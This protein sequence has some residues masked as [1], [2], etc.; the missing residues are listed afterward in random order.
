MTISD[1]A[2][3]EPLLRFQMIAGFDGL[4]RQ[5]NGVS[6]LEEDSFRMPGGNTNP[7]DFLL[8]DFAFA[9]DDHDRPFEAVR[10]L[11]E[12]DAA[13]LAV[14][15]IY[16]PDLD[17]RVLDYADDNQ[18]PVFLFDSLS[19]TDV[20]FSIYNRLNGQK[21]ADFYESRLRQMFPLPVSD[22]VILQNVLEINPTF[23]SNYYCAYL[24]PKVPSAA[25]T[26]QNGLL[27]VPNRPYS[28]L[29]RY[30][31][32]WLLLVSFPEKLPAQE[33]EGHFRNLLSLYQLE[34]NKFFCGLSLIYHDL[35]Q[36]DLCLAEAVCASRLAEKEQT[37]LIWYS[38]MGV[39]QFLLPQLRSK[40][41]LKQ[42]QAMRS[43]LEEYDK[44]Y[45]SNLMET[46][47]TYVNCEGKLAQT[48]QTLYLH[49]N[50]V[51]Y[52][53]DKLRELLGPE[54]FFVQAYLFVKADDFLRSQRILP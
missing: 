5:V 29:V 28:S 33:Q 50:T 51:R 12:R 39:Y 22:A 35:T 17:Q 25:L 34:Q 8:T 9:K 21:Q 40:G 36:F 42:V 4:M 26:V 53:L 6:V 54:D 43:V 1:L 16:F 47:Y 18:F 24:T 41:I 31:K 27:P 3:L 19:L 11:I 13:G 30:E 23:Q 49:V 38:R 46:L 14:K 15:T 20:L 7:G 2:M 48:A 52:R 32:G 37:P 45:N 10:L 44:K